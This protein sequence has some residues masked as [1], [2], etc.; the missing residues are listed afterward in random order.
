[1][2]KRIL[3][4]TIFVLLLAVPNLTAQTQSSFPGTASQGTMDIPNPLPVT[5]VPFIDLTVRNPQSG[6]EVA[7]SLQLLLL[8]TVLALA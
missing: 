2:M 3:L 4:S 1:M 7:F 6:Q 5:G 8:L